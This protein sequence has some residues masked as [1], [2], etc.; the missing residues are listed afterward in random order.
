MPKPFV[1]IFPDRDAIVRLA[2]AVLSWPGK[3]TSGPNNA[4]AG[5]PR[6]SPAAAFT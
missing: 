3:A 5:G 4:A 1:G 6:S 2:G